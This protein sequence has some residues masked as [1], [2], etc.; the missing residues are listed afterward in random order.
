MV[1]TKSS[2]CFMVSDMDNA[3]HAALS[4]GDWHVASDVEHVAF[5]CAASVNQLAITTFAALLTCIL[6]PLN[7]ALPQASGVA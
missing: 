5:Q 6:R 1:P 4:S 7:R 3:G 2:Q